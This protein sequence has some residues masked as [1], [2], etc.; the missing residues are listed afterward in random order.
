MKEDKLYR[1]LVSKMHE[2][3]VVPPQRIGPLTPIYKRLVLR[4]KFYPWVST[5]LIASVASLFLYILLGSHLVKFISIL[6]FGF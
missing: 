2:V 3:A 5:G 1:L 4:L 6:Q